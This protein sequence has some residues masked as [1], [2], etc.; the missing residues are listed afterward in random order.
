MEFSP[1][2]TVTARRR[3]LRIA[4]GPSTFPPRSSDGN[5]VT[6]V[7]KA[8]KTAVERARSGGG[9][10]FIEAHTYRIQGHLEAEDLFPGWTALPGTRGNRGAGSRKDRFEVTRKQL[11]AG[12]PAAVAQPAG[13]RGAGDGQLWMRP[14]ASRWR[15]HRPI[16]SWRSRW[17]FDGRET[18]RGEADMAKKRHD[19]GNQRSAVP[20]EMELTRSFIL[21]GEDVELSAIMDDCRG[22]DRALWPQ[23]HP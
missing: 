3:Y 17:M 8:A 4:P 22:P 11:E 13:D 9:P 21:F 10:S 12:G 1:A 18:V 16:R 5:D 19:P 7:W 2:K 15:A 20:E 23:S 6:A 14:C